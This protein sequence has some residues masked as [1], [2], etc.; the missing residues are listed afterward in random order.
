MLVYEVNVH[1]PTREPH[2]PPTTAPAK[3]IPVIYKSVLTGILESI[4]VFS[5][6]MLRLY[7]DAQV[8]N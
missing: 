8:Y 5:S 2:A 7:S 4:R 1:P 3:K 6:Q